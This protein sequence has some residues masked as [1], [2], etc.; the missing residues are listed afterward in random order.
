MSFLLEYVIFAAVMVANLGLGLHFALFKRS[1]NMSTSEMFLG[2][3]TLKTLPLA[4][5]MFASIVSSSGIVVFTGHFYAYGF[6][7][8]WGAVAALIVLPVSV[9]V[10]IPVLYKL[11]VTSI[12]EY[13]RM[14]YGQYAA[15]TACPIYFFLMESNGAVAIYAASVA[16][17]AIFQVPIL[18]SA[19]AVGL[20]GTFYAALGGLRGVVWTDCVQALLSV[21]A[22]LAVIIKI[23]CDSKKEPVKLEPLNHWDPKPYFLE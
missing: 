21:L 15:L 13:I 1:A 16:V 20:T 4:F 7:F 9:Y 10:I 18:W 6:H 11:K 8:A 3:R 22:P 5:S 2:N 19:L 23:I 17:S 14:R 12:F